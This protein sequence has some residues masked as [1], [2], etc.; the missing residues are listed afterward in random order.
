M[1]IA[2]HNRTGKEFEMTDEQFE[3]F[4]Q[5]GSFAGSYS[6]RQ[7]PKKGVA[8][9]SKTETLKPNENVKSKTKK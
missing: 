7:A 4:K 6:F 1:I 3:Q 2:K 9:V 8:P 5:H